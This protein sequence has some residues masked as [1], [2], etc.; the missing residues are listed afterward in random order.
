[1]AI[2]GLGAGLDSLF[3]DNASEIQVKKTLRTSEI[4]PN[5]DQPR[6]VF[7]EEAIASLAES[8]REHGIFTADTCQTACDRWLSDCCRRTALESCKDVRS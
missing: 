2:G 7:S 6:K 8:I 4:E 5:R 1:M 3:S